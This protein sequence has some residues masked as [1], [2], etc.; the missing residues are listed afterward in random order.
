VRDTKG[1]LFLVKEGW[2]SKNRIAEVDFLKAVK[3]LRGV[4]QMIAY[5]E[6][7]NI[8]DLRGSSDSSLRDRTWSR[9]TLEAY[10][11]PI[12]KFTSREQLL[13]AFR[14][15]IAGKLCSSPSLYRLTNRSIF[16]RSRTPV[17]RFDSTPGCQYQ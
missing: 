2:R 8:S 3:G 4:G 17:E 5:E 12:Y 15:A 14:D 9:I 16:W 11:K 6:G 13:V 7:E 10:G 1:N